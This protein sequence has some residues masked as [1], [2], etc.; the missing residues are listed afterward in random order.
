MRPGSPPCEVTLPSLPAVYTPTSSGTLSMLEHRERVTIAS[1]YFSTV[2]R[3]RVSVSLAEAA[4]RP[5]LEV[6]SCE[7]SV[8]GVTRDRGTATSPVSGIILFE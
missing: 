8:L 5:G 1:C 2:L 4:I 7:I 3:L 6:R